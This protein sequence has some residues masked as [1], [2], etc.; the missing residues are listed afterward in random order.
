MPGGDDVAESFRFAAVRL[1]ALLDL[2]PIAQPGDDLAPSGGL[3]QLAAGLEEALRGSLELGAPA[4]D[5]R[6]GHRQSFGGLGQVCPRRAAVLGGGEA[7][8]LVFPSR[9]R[10]GGGQAGGA[11]FGQLDGQSTP[12]GLLR[13]LAQAQ[14]DAQPKVSRHQ[15]SLRGPRSGPFVPAWN[16]LGRPSPGSNPAAVATVHVSSG[17]WRRNASTASRAPM[18]ASIAGLE[19]EA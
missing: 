3:G 1:P 15:R 7:D 2:D 4:G 19:P 11:V 5:G 6:F 8:E 10:A 12:R 9:D 17:V 18:A 14:D 16:G 13:Q